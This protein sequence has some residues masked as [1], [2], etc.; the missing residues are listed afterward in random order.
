MPLGIVHV[1]FD[2]AGSQNLGGWSVRLSR[3]CSRFGATVV[4]FRGRRRGSLVFWRSFRDRRKGSELLY[5]EMQ[6]F[7]A[8]TALWTWW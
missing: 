6:F 3:L 5:F 4:T 2:C 8:G 1:H 7:V